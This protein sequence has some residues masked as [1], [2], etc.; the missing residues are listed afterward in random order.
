MF[1]PDKCGKEA[2]LRFIFQHRNP[3]TG[4]YQ[5]LVNVHQ[6]F[7][8]KLRV[9]TRSFLFYKEK[10]WKE[11]S[12]LKIE[13]LINDKKSHQYTLMI[14]PDSTFQIFVD[15]KIVGDGS[16]LHDVS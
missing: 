12:T 10:H 1:G 13:E 15:E 14:H 7:A 11:P 16:L 4:A 9:L 3:V 2:H 6:N 8:M 5:V